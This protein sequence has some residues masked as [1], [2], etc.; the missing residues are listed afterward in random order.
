MKI[1]IV[2]GFLGAGK[3]TFLTKI[4]PL[5]QEKVGII[6][7]EVGDVSIDGYAF[8]KDFRVT[9]V[10]GGCICCTVAKDLKKAVL[11]LMEEEKVEHIWIEPS[12]IAH[13]SAILKALSDIETQLEIS[14]DYQPAIVLVDVKDFNDYH[15]SMGSF[16]TDQI[17][18][19]DIILLSRF[20]DEKPEEM[21]R[22]IGKLRQHNPEASILQEEWLTM[23]N[24]LLET[25]LKENQLKTKKTALSLDSGQENVDSSDTLEKTTLKKA[26]AFTQEAL[27]VLESKFLENEWGNVCRAKGHLNTPEGKTIHFNYTPGRFC[28]ELQDAFIPSALTVI[29]K[30]LEKEKIHEYFYEKKIHDF[31][32]QNND[33]AGLPEIVINELNLAFPQAYQESEAMMQI[34]LSLKKYAGSPHCELPFCHTVEGE[35]LGA[36]IRYGDETVGPRSGEAVCQSAEDLLALPPMN[37]TQGRISAL[38]QACNKLTEQGEKVVLYLSGPLTILNTLMDARVLFKEIKRKP[39]QMNR[40]FD[41]LRGETLRFI[42]EAQKNGVTL[43]SYGDSVGGANIIGPHLS[44]KITTQYTYP[45]M[46]TIDTQML[47]ENSMMI[48]CPKTAYALVGTGYAHWEDFF[49]SEPMHYSEGCLEAV[50]SFNFAGQMC[51]KNRSFYL[52]N[53]ILKGLRLE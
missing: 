7:N 2:S 48:L 40:V 6:E 31:P 20:C 23:E 34:A 44:E 21:D 17:Q 28:W 36:R 4:L 5:V 15:Q 13:L 10:F 3:T 47:S 45:L 46:K 25:L 24:V 19:A 52:E 32:C 37:F 22:I 29:G 38:L 18:H 33:M 27:Q 39:D 42:K 16:Y 1:S 43:F 49:L 41:F 35:A 26:K 14:F 51:I 53:K 30:S 11:Y 9:E 8:E 50:S 12:G